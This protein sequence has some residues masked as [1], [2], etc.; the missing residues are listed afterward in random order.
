MEIIPSLTRSSTLSC[1]HSAPEKDH[2]QGRYAT[3]RET[4][5]AIAPE[6][7][8]RHQGMQ[9]RLAVTLN[10][11]DHHAL[12]SYEQ[13]TPFAHRID[14]I[15]ERDLQ[16]SQNQHPQDP[17]SLPSTPTP[18]E[19]SSP[20]P[21]GTE[22]TVRDNGEVSSGQSNN[23]NGTQIPPPSPA[24]EVQSPQIPK[25]YP[26]P[27]N[28]L[29][30]GWYYLY[31]ATRTGTWTPEESP[32]GSLWWRYEED[33][34]VWKYFDPQTGLWFPG[35]YRDDVVL[36]GVYNPPTTEFWGLFPKQGGWYYFSANN[37]HWWT[38][39][40]K[41][42]YLLSFSSRLQTGWKWYRDS[43]VTDIRWW[44]PCCEAHE[45]PKNG[46]GNADQE[47]Q[48]ESQLPSTAVAFVCRYISPLT[49]DFMGA[50]IDG[51]PAELLPANGLREIQN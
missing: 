8:H 50:Q 20:N 28:G 35:P 33:G 25:L 37:S 14:A 22:V 41:S 48:P 10:A 34:E 7:D 36:S 45:T 16:A 1:E 32:E 19:H 9:N 46:N 44:C 47:R 40:D 3:P 27:T 13:H 49:S 38:Y 39:F 11:I 51:P 18:H 4:F 24:A 29:R 23:N 21:T 42:W 15:I 6:T 17:L 2:I 5:P 43:H 12:D 30:T 26:S 31:C